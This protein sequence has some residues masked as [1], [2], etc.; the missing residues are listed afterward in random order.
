M[1]KKNLLGTLAALACIASATAQPAP[2]LQPAR[3]APDPATLDYRL[4]PRQIAPGTWVIEGAVADFRPA[5][6][7]NIINTAFIATGDG[8]I[9]INTGPSRL[10]GE[11]QRRAIAAGVSAYVASGVPSERIKPVIEVA[12]ARFEQEEKLREEKEAAKLAK[13]KSEARGF[14]Q[15]GSVTVN[16]VKIDA[17]DHQFGDGERLYGRFTL[18]RR[19][20]KNYAMLNWI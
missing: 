9:V 16:G 5:N 15:S 11:Q 14:L 18:L 4:Q 7:C 10:Y 19:G 8:V 3:A 1:K 13:S 2:P 17:L 12:M 6:G 20:K